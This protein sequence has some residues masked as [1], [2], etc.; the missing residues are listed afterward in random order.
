MS[1]ATNKYPKT[2][3]PS[4]VSNLTY[5]KQHTTTLVGSGVSSN[6]IHLQPGVELYPDHVVYAQFQ[7]QDNDYSDHANQTDPTFNPVQEYNYLQ[8]FESNLADINNSLHDSWVLQQQQIA[9][10]YRFDNSCIGVVVQFDNIEQEPLTLR[11]RRELR[12]QQALTLQNEQN[13]ENQQNSQNQQNQPSNMNNSAVNINSEPNSASQSNSAIPSS[14]NTPVHKT[15]TLVLPTDQNQQ[16][17]QPLTPS[18]SSQNGSN[19]TNHSNNTNKNSFRQGVKQL[20]SRTKEFFSSSNQPNGT[21][22]TANNGLTPQIGPNGQNPQIA[23]QNPN[24]NLNF[25]K[26]DHNQ[27]STNTPRASVTLSTQQQTPN[28]QQKPPIIKQQSHPSTTSKSSNKSNNVNN[29]NTTGVVAQRNLSHSNHQSTS[30]SPIENNNINNNTGHSTPETPTTT[31]SQHQPSQSNNTHNMMMNEV[32]FSSSSEIIHSSA[33]TPGF[34]PSNHH[35]HGHIV[36]L[37]H[38]LHIPN[39][40]ISQKQFHLQQQQLKQQFYPNQTPQVLPQYH[41]NNNNNNVNNRFNNNNNNTHDNSDLN[42]V[43]ILQPIDLNHP[44]VPINTTQN[45]TYQLN[46]LNKNNNNNDNDND[47]PESNNI[48]LSGENSALSASQPL[49]K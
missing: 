16:Q 1:S 32:D 7:H 18:N 17:I 24:P 49:M 9:D 30:N 11:Q 8:Y 36:N 19:S 34:G 6:N 31:L 28:D 25:G 48:G 14:Q 37:D 35:R 15:T 21:N 33:T 12:K 27:P 29:L 5:Q 41:S 47:G 43:D 44:A 42:D 13:S 4:V 10:R 22:Q 2:A 39:D 20:F 45:N 26:D 40:L 3:A 23:K 46:N 38:H